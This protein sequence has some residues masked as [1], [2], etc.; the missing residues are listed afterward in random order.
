MRLARRNWR[1]SSFAGRGFHFPGP[2]PENGNRTLQIHCCTETPPNLSPRPARQPGTRPRPPPQ[3]AG[4]PRRATEPRLFC[5]LF[6]L[7]IW[8]LTIRIL[9]SPISDVPSDLQIINLRRSIRA[10]KALQVWQQSLEPPA[11]QP[12]VCSRA[13]AL[14]DSLHYYYM[15]V[16]M[17]IDKTE[18]ATP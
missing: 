8:I 18:D 1:I 3:S 6:S 13:V 10:T 7:T 4:I 14:Q 9:S 11:F 2:R 15:Y 5:N 17:G 16:G 12:A